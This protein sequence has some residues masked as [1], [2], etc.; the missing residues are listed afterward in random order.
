[1]D[2]FK[3]S[4]EKA[5]HALI[6]DV[7]EEINNY[8]VS[9]I[10]SELKTYLSC[11]IHARMMSIVIVNPICTGQIFLIQLNALLYLIMS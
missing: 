3:F 11:D 4:Q 6:L 10:H 7:V 1:M 5:I 2:D 9:L 8:I